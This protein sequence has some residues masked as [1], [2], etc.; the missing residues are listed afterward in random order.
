MIF[1]TSQYNADNTE[2]HETEFLTLK[3]FQLTG[4]RTYPGNYNNFL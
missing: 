2:I 4:E 3:K 1:A